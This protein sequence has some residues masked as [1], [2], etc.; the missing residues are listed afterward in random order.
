MPQLFEAFMMICFGISWPTSIVKSYRSRTAAGT[1]IVFQ[2][3]IFSGYVFGISAKLISGQITYVLILYIIN[4]CMIS[5]DICLY[6][7]N[8]RLDAERAAGKGSRATDTLPD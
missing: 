4:L 7:R 3:L 6:F 1:S 2:C 5:V 8:K